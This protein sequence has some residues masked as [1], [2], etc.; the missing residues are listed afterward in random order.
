MPIVAFPVCLLLQRSTD[1]GESPNGGMVYVFIL[2]GTMALST[3]GW[4]ERDH[5]RT[6]PLRTLPFT[7][8]AILACV[9]TWKRMLVCF[10]SVV[11]TDLAC[12]GLGFEWR[13]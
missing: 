13:G 8:E 3:V 2:L 7:K 5:V 11:V 10:V 9:P 1:L 4:R 12:K 6:G